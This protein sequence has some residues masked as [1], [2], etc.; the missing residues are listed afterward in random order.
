MLN[1]IHPKFS[2]KI[3]TSLNRCTLN[4]Y[5]IFCLKVKNCLNDNFTH[6]N[7][8]PLHDLSVYVQKMFEGHFEKL[9]PKLFIVRD[10][11]IDDGDDFYGFMT[12]LEGV[13]T[14]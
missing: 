3:Q 5:I 11:Y 1:L 2:T 6:K 10:I 13:T 4:N 8:L 12:N 7:S 14:T 9:S